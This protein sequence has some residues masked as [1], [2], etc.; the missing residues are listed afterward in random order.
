MATGA[1]VVNSYTTG[2]TIRHVHLVAGGK[3]SPLARQVDRSTRASPMGQN[4]PG[5]KNSRSQDG[6]S[7]EEASGSLVYLSRW[8]EP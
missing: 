3:K 4:V 8:R 2:S 1:G 5:G 6:G 7:Q